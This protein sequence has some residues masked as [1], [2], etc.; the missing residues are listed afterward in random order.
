M[1]TKRMNLEKRKTMKAA[2]TK[3]RPL[4]NYVDF[5]GMVRHALDEKGFEVYRV[6][7][8]PD[9]KSWVAVSIKTKPP[10]ILV[11]SDRT[12]VRDSESRMGAIETGLTWLFRKYQSYQWRLNGGAGQ[13]DHL[14]DDSKEKEKEKVTTDDDQ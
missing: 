13:F 6:A 1:F 8:E 5:L 11:Y 12:V 2:K 9:F 7:G 3:T 4:A 10:I 14:I